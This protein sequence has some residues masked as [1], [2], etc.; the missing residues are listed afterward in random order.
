MRI[1]ESQEGNEIDPNFEEGKRDDDPVN[2]PY[3]PIVSAMKMK[4]AGNNPGISLETTTKYR[5]KFIKDSFYDASQVPL[6]KKE[7]LDFLLR[8][9]DENDPSA[10]NTLKEMIEEYEKTRSRKNKTTTQTTI[11]FASVKKTLR[12]SPNKRFLRND[13]DDVPDMVGDAFTSL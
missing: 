9:W 11:P 6:G 2:N 3:I 1:L 5:K 13:P 10:I 12:K 8:K 4:N 7:F